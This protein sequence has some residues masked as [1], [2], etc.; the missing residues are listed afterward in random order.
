VDG[1]LREE[2]T[3]AGL[4]LVREETLPHPLGGAG[5]SLLHYELRV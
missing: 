1:W 5:V 2:L 3:G 4:A